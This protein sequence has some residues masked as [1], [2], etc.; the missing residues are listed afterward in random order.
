MSKKN[1]KCFDVETYDGGCISHFVTEAKD[2]K[3]AL[4]NMLKNSSDFKNVIKSDKDL[5]IKIKKI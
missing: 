5:T 2:H 3:Q 1:L 4:R